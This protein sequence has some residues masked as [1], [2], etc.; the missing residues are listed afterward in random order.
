MLGVGA[1][2][3]ELLIIHCI[4]FVFFYFWGRRRTLAPVVYSYQ[5]NTAGRVDRM[6]QRGR[7]DLV[8]GAG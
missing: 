7:N 8:W 1:K 3:N 2:C 5:V 4:F 6:A